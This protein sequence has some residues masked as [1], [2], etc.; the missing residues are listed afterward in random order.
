MKN[1]YHDFHK[2]YPKLK[3]NK[4]LNLKERK[5][6]AYLEQSVFLSIGGSVADSPQSLGT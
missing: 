2:L 5:E 1:S 3:H 4:K 6:E